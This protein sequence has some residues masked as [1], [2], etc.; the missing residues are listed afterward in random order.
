M[1]KVVS[2]EDKKYLLRRSGLEPILFL[3]MKKNTVVIRT[4]RGL[5]VG[6]L[7]DFENRKL[8][9]DEKSF[10][11][12]YA[13]WFSHQNGKPNEALGMSEEEFEKQFRNI[14]A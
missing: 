4:S 9:M 14:F 12:A 13:S 8:T 5:Y 7:V 10:V 11:D 6:R 3:H 1:I 2:F